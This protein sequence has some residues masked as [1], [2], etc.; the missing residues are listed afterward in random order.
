MTPPRL[1][2]VVGAATPVTLDVQLKDG[3]VMDQAVDGGHRH[4]GVGEHVVPARERLVGRDQQAA[5]L[6]PLGDQLEQHA[7]LGLVLAHVRQVIKDDQVDA[8]QLA[9][10][11][12]Q[13]QALAGHLQLLNDLTG[14]REQHTVAGIDQ[15]V[16]DAGA[17]MRLAAARRPEQQDRGAFLQS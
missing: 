4:R 5:P 6:V 3:R 10:H 7:R 14:A 16:T 1:L 8:V 11:R 12:R 9:E 17:Q 15:G 2:V 13:L